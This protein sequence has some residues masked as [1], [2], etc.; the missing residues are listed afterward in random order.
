MGRLLRC[1][2]FVTAL[3]V[4]VFAATDAGLA[5]TGDV[6]R[7]AAVLIIETA[8]RICGESQTEGSGSTLSAQGEADA[9]I[10]V[11]SKRLL[12]L[13]IEGAANLQESEYRNVLREQLADELKDARQCRQRVFGQMFATVFG[14]PVRNILKEETDEVLSGSV[15]PH[16]IEVIPSGE[17]FVIKPQESVAL[18]KLARMFTV[19]KVVENLNLGPLVYFNWVNAASGES[20]NNRYVRQAQPIVLEDCSLVPY[21]IDVEGQS[22]SFLTT[23]GQ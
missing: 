15:L 18:G 14:S 3:S 13:G 6:Q 16:E 9:S 19:N 1:L 22:V 2:P 20:V 8:E 23:C 4:P 7:D 11:L 12:G 17:Q 5:Q 21:R 10:N